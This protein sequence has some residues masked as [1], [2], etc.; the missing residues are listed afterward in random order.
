MDISAKEEIDS[1]WEE[2]R[3]RKPDIL[4]NNAGIYPFKNFLEI[5]HAFFQEGDGHKFEFG[6]LNEPAHDREKVEAGRN[7]HK[8]WLY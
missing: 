8:Y 5:D 2:L 1:L 7:N 3:G 6:S 4:V